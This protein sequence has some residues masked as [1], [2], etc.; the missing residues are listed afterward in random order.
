MTVEKANAAYEEAAKA[1]EAAVK[2]AQEAAA[3]TQ[4][5]GKGIWQK[6]GFLLHT[7]PQN[8]FHFD[9][10]EIAQLW[11]ILAVKG[12]AC[13]LSLAFLLSPSR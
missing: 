9:S 12:L 11:Q 6:A 8:L 5:S 1:A 10:V 7:C 4:E 2:K 13:N 3:E